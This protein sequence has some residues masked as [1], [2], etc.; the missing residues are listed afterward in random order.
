MSDAGV[1]D[2]IKY[3]A[4][5]SGR[6]FHR[7]LL[8][9]FPRLI[10]YLKYSYVA[11]VARRNGATIG[12]AVS[13]PLALAKRATPNL[14]IGN[15]VSIQ[16]AAIDCRGVVR[17]GDHVIIGSDVEILTASHDVDSSKWETKI[18]GIEIESYAWIA[19][20]VFVLPS[21]R[22]IGQGAVCAAGAVV[23]REVQPMSIVS[24]NP[25]QEIRVRKKVHSDLCVESLLG[26]DFLAYVAAIKKNRQSN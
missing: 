16:T 3:A 5:I 24:G 15:H 11:A 20:R 21:C 6:P 7:K 10:S 26:N 22:K 12:H 19:T 9:F 17:I 23:A 18:Y 4:T 1:V 13:M 25:A 2:E 8:G 14:H